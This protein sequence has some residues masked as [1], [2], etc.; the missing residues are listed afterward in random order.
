M[1]KYIDHIPDQLL[2]SNAS[3]AKFVSI[4][5]EI[6]F[7]KDNETQKFREFVS[8]RR[9]YTLNN[10][11]RILDELGFPY[12]E[13]HTIAQL[14]CV[15]ENSRYI[16]SRKGTLT[17]LEKLLSCF[18]GE[19]TFSN[20]IL[21]PKKP[22]LLSSDTIFWD[23][24]PG[25]DELDGEI[26]ANLGEEMYV[27]T[28]PGSTWDWYKDQLIVDVLVPPFPEAEED[29]LQVLIEKMIPM[30]NTDFLR[31]TLNKNP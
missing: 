25:E 2:G 18:Y 3:I 12:L 29:F 5:E 30:S 8:H 22:M 24:V 13:S 1:D 6:Q 15:I 16:L 20:F 28:P 23:Q 4:L 31:L 26:N 21:I 14:G 19:G 10:I 11:R 9:I 7:L 17:A 27:A